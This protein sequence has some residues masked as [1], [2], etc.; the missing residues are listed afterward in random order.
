MLL[1]F[2]GQQKTRNA[3]IHAGLWTSLDFL[4]LL[5]GAGLGIESASA[6]GN[7]SV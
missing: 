4:K 2:T 1:H 5:D 7:D 6:R 3:L